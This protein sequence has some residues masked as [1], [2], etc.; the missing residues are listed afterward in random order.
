MPPNMVDTAAEEKAWKR[1]KARAAKQGHE[2]D[3]PYVVA[4]FQKMKKGTAKGISGI[5]AN[6]GPNVPR[7][8]PTS[9]MGDASTWVSRSTE[10]AKGPYAPLINALEK[11][12]VALE[13][14]YQRPVWSNPYAVVSGIKVHIEQLP[15]EQRNG[16]TMAV[17]Y[18][19]VIGTMGA[20]G[21]PFDVY[22]GQNKTAPMVY[23]IDQLDADGEVDE[24][25][26]MVGFDTAED[27]AHAYVMQLPV[28]KMG[29]MVA[30]SAPALAS[31]L[32]NHSSVSA[33]PFADLLMEAG[34]PCVKV[35]APL[36]GVGPLA[37]PGVQ[38]ANGAV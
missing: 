17:G 11:A 36:S 21:E 35:W 6:F 2:E 10:P 24:H 9:G 5:P 8:D 28:S 25:K 29:G 3:W 33:E 27:A 19:E 14:E 38:Q 13:P 31:F 20:D 26:A 7:L 22:V 1:A 34:V 23:V 18:G 30:V 15:G 37:S 12:T 16:S 32:A 4:I